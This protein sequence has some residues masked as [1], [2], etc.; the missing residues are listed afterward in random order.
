MRA[1]SFLPRLYRSLG[2]I[3][4]EESEALEADARQAYDKVNT[5]PENSEG[6]NKGKV[7]KWT[8]EHDLKRNVGEKMWF[9]Q[10]LPLFLLIAKRY[11]I[12]WTYAP[13]QQPLQQP[14]AQPYQ[15][16]G[17]GLN[18]PIPPQN[19][20]APPQNGQQPFSWL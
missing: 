19:Q 9:R 3:T 17:Y 10:L 7:Q 11:I 20:A 2:I 15:P 13:I 5:L 4:G 6:E 14:Q 1:Y 18:N 16:N 8:Y 12:M